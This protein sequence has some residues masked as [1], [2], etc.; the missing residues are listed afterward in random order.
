MNPNTTLPDDL[1]GLRE[2]AERLAKEEYEC[3]LRLSNSS[4]ASDW[5]D[6]AGTDE[7]PEDYA[8]TLCIDTQMA[9]L[10]DLTRRA[11]RNWAAEW[12]ASRLDLSLY[13]ATA[14]AWYHHNAG[15]WC[16]D[17]Q[18]GNHVFMGK[19]P[20]ESGWDHLTVV[21]GIGSVTDPTIALCMACVAVAGAK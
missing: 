12:L 18:D 8:R 19:Q 1:P 6:M 3:S 7:D 5:N 14:P 20:R 10:G 16:L 2:E 11:S 9:L 15:Y 17:G 21:P 13:S 4:C